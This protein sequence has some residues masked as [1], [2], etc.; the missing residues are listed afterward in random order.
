ME[1][2][3]EG[4]EGC[5][6]SADATGYRVELETKCSE[7]QCNL[8]LLPDSPEPF[9]AKLLQLLLSLFPPE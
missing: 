3:V 6:T 7:S 4:G 2:G 8:P 1:V 5:R 9:T